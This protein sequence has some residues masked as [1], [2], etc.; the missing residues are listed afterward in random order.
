[1]SKYDVIVI[2]GGP[3]GYVASIR[4]AQLGLHTACVEGRETLGGTC[5]NVGCIPSKALLHASHQLHEAQHNFEKMGL[6]AKPPSIDWAKMQNYKNETIDANTKGIEFLFKKNKI[7]HLKGWASIPAPGKVQIDDKIFETENIII[8]SGSEPSTIPN[9]E[10]DEKVIV[11]STGALSLPKIPKT[12]TVIGAGV[13]G[14]ELGSVYARLGTK[15]TIIEYLDYITPGMDKEV[16]KTFLRIL[17]KQGIS[18]VMGAAVQSASKSKSVG[19]VKY[20]LNKDDSLHELAGNTILV[21]TGRKPNTN[22]LGLGKLNMEL[23]ERG[24]IKTDSGW[25]TNIPSIYAIGDVVEGPMLAHK[26]EDEGMA[27]AEQIAGKNGHVNYQVIPSVVY[28][29]PE[30]ASVGLTEQQAK[31]S[32][33]SIKIGKFMFMGNGRA[34]ANFAADGFVKILADKDVIV[35]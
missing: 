14:L 18:F 21:A 35:F 1:M 26:A 3:G 17:K 16:Q 22:G 23:T 28:T 31:D 15:V 11:S 24:Q 34:K 25:Q 19:T 7:D 5:L 2:G 9:V 13:I 6:I 27:V 30:V 20:K 32:D 10:I 12:M 29:A 4:C 33:R 8:A